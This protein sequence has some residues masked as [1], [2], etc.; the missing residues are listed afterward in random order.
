MN[1]VLLFL[2]FAATGIWAQGTGGLKGVI[3]APDGLPVPLAI[4]EAR[5][6][7]SGVASSA[8]TSSTGEYSIAKL[9]AGSYDVTVSSI[10]YLAPGEKK[11]FAVAGDTRLD[12]K[13]N[14]V[15]MGGTPGEGH[16]AALSSIRRVAPKGP[17]PRLADGKPDL[18]GVWSW[19]NT[20]DPGLAAFLPAGA[21]NGELTPATYC[22]P[23][24]VLWPTPYIKL[25]HTPKLMIVLYDDED[26]AYRQ[27]YLDGRAHPK[28]EDPTWWGHSVGHWEKDTLVVDRVGFNGKGWLDPG[29]HRYTE[30]LHVVERYRRPDLG[31]LE[32]E[33]TMEDPGVL[34]GSWTVKRLS[35]LAPEQDVR[36]YPCNENNVD[37]PHMK[38]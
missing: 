4:V 19:P 36:E 1:R 13:L 23:H 21:P 16:E 35:I 8:T 25:V 30:Q 32:L 6:A 18:S 37:P 20:T 22:L 11:G 31:H 12:F 2:I 27:I 9:P 3:T 7:Q 10:R 29:G 14:Y 38:K 5:N 28:G 15:V 26:P 17:T 33:T 34:K 24:A